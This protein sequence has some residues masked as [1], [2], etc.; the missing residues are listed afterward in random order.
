M[1]NIIF[2]LFVI[3]LFHSG[4]AYSVVDSEK[5]Q[6]DML[7]ET[8]DAGQRTLNRLMQDYY[9]ELFEIEPELYEERAVKVAAYADFNVFS[10][11]KEKKI[12]FPLAFVFEIMLQSKALMQ[13]YDESLDMTLYQNYLQ[14]LELRTKKSLKDKKEVPIEEF[15][16]WAGLTP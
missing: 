5:T 2:I 6:D 8:Q 10:S 15:W 4:F 1:K 7:Q 3:T 16:K 13:V 14:Y 11:V 12:I 9:G